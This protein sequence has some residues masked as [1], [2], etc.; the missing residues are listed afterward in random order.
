MKL[1][2]HSKDGEF[3]NL[4]LSSL[5]PSSNSLSRIS[6]TNRQ[7]LKELINYL[8]KLKKDEIL[9]EKQYNEL[10]VLACANFIENEV[11]ARISKSLN[12]KIMLFFEKL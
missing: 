4:L 12:D 3:I 9:D 10:V 1:V 11:E 5:K 2:K 8:S 7:T 6:E